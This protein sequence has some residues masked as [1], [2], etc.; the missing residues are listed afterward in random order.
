[1]NSK[2]KPRTIHKRTNRER[3]DVFIDFLKIAHM[4]ASITFDGTR[5]LAICKH[6]KLITQAVF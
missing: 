4:D 6:A 1:M 5:P 2:S 3:G